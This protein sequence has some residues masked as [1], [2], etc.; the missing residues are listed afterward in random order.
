MGPKKN[1]K[2]NEDEEMWNKN[3]KNLE[4]ILKKVKNTK[5]QNQRAF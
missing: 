4:E 5:N 3:E 1:K 2:Q